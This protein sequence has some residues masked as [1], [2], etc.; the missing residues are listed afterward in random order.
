MNLSL[1]WPGIE[2]V[3][4]TEK[5]EFWVVSLEDGYVSLTLWKSSKEVQIV[6]HGANEVV[7]MK[8]KRVNPDRLRKMLQRMFIPTTQKGSR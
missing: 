3:C 5:S 7:L 2:R 4:D 1:V 6:H 8:F